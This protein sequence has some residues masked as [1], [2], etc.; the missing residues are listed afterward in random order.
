MK[1]DEKRKKAY[2]NEERYLG[3]VVLLEVGEG[4]TRDPMLAL[5]LT[6]GVLPGDCTNKNY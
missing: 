5:T 3:K 1:K 2:L 4:Y 6:L